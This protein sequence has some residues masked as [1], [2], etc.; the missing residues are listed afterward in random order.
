MLHRITSSRKYSLR[1]E[2]TLTNQIEQ[3]AEWEQFR[4]YDESNKLVELA[5]CSKK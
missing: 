2:Y 3:F 5:L 1:V 4:L